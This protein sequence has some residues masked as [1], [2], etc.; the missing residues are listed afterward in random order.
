[1]SKAVNSKSVKNFIGSFWASQQDA[2]DT[3]VMKEWKVHNFPDRKLTIYMPKQ[4]WTSS[5]TNFVIERSDNSVRWEANRIAKNLT[6]S[7][8]V[9][10]RFGKFS[11]RICWLTHRTCFWISDRSK[12]SKACGDHDTEWT[13][14]DL[15]YLLNKTKMSFSTIINGTKDKIFSIIT[16]RKPISSSFRHSVARCSTL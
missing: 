12:H 2:T 16:F 6:M 11:R 13:Y 1:M 7:P 9:T 4:S 3:W 10:Y 5:F 15:Q 8:S 14:L